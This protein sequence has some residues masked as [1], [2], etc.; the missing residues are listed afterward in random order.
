MNRECLYSLS[1]YIYIYINIYI[2][3]KAQGTDSKHSA[4]L[5]GLEIIL[6]FG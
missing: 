3:D 5:S 6:S 4:L 1:T 2:D